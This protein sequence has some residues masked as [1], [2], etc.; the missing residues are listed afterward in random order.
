VTI[1]AA[2]AG[3]ARA[4]VGGTAATAPWVVSLKQV[5]KTG[6][7][8]VCTGAVLDPLHV[9]T[10]GH[11][12]FDLSGAV[13]DPSAL[14]VRAGISNYA[15]PAAG[16]AEQD[17]GVS[18]FR[19]HPGFV[20][21]AGVSADD[22]AVLALTGPL[23]LSTPQVQAAPLPSGGTL[24]PAQA[25][26]L[27]AGFGRE[28][29][30]AADGSLNGFTATVD[31]QGECGSFSNQVVPYADAIAF[32]AAGPSSA[33]CNGDSGAPLVTADAAH[34]IVGIVSAGPGSC[35]PGSHGVYTNVDAREI[36]DFIHG[37]DHP[38][39]APRADRTTYALLSGEPPL[40]TGSTLTCRSGN[41]QGAPSLTYAFV[42]TGTGRVIQQGPNGS[43]VLTAQTAGDTV[44]CR[45]TASTPGG[46]AVLETTS[47][48]AVGGVPNLVIER[49][50][51]VTGR[52]GHTASIR[53]WLD[54]ASG[55]TGRFGVCVAPP[56]RVAPRACASQHVSNGGGGRFPVSVSLRL[57]RTAPLGA[58]KLTVSAV[59]GPSHGRS[60][61]VLRVAR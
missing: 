26:V 24:Y 37:D 27:V 21:S 42:D 8:L 58:A 35:T 9:L 19:V 39:A 56:P 2:P 30:G 55:L 50:P 49:V 32:C 28:S 7:T 45:V 46:T 10:A 31:P 22:V 5:T 16:D 29:N 34:V 17:R 40:H 38:A 60:T 3:G 20:Y 12:V 59:A 47:T 61:A 11:C 52:R 48:E 25:T 23:D 1:A 6:S 33:V 57:A 53:V 15:T 44:A 41:W 4:V 43:L 36:L 54:P 18:S 51:A 13:A 14:S